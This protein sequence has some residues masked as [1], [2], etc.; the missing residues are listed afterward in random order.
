VPV[1]TKVPNQPT[2]FNNIAPI[3]G[4]DDRIIFTSDRPRNGERQLYPQLDEYEELATVTACGACS[5]RTAICHDHPHAERGVLACWTAPGA[6]SMSAGTISSATSR[7]TRTGARS[8][9]LRR[10]QLD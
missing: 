10:V 4:S 9:N 6:L 2:N 3:Y 1:I 7:R 8:Y 5:R